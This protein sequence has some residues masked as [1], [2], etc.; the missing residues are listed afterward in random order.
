MFKRYLSYIEVSTKITSLY[1]FLMTVS[2][3]FSIGQK[4]DLFKSLVFFLS[5]L[6]FDMTATAI[7]NYEDTKNN[8]QELQF[9]RKTALKIIIIQ[10]AVSSGLG[11]YLALITDAVVLL[12]GMLCFLFGIIYSFGPVSISRLPL[13]EFFSGLFY[14]LMIPF[15]LLYINM[16]EG[17]YLTYSADTVSVDFSFKIIPIIQVLLLSIV[18]FCATAG[19]ML[20]NNI[21]DL[22]KDTAVKRF[23]LPYYIGTKASLYL[24]AGLYYLIYL[25]LIIMVIFGMLPPICLISLFTFI[26]IQKNIAKFHG[27]QEK[28]VT[29]VL[30]VKNYLI[31]M[32]S[33]TVLIFISGLF[34]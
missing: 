32:T 17:T 33:V 30:S 13:G 28:A 29:F 9:N 16:P 10:L 14:G 6:L 23:T 24:F 34:T 31:I 25:A 5:M 3:L 1:A 20:A 7:N 8:R 11:I 15:I 19:I 22:Q 12:L 2:Y 18:P 21:C 4:P 27:K 26:P